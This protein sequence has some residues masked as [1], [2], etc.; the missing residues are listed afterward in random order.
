MQEFA[1]FLALKTL[2]SHHLPKHMRLV[3]TKYNHE[4]DRPMGL[5]RPMNVLMFCAAFAFVAAV[6][7]GIFP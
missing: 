6:I 2:D 4:G 7:V 5:T 1:L 3:K